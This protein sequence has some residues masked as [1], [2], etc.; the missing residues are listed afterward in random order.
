MA[1]V[2]NKVFCDTV[3]EELSG[4]KKRLID[5]KMRSG[6][7]GGEKEI[8]DLFDRHLAELVDAIDWKIQ[9]L[10]HSCPYDWA[11]SSAYENPVEV[12]PSEK[13]TEKEFSPGYLGG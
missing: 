6:Q 5:L 11:G 1:T 2:K 10:S 7:E 4:I 8:A 9:I 13:S 12:Q 3:Y